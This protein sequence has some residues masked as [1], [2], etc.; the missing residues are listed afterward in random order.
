MNADQAVDRLLSRPN[1]PSEAEPYWMAFCDLSE[2]RPKESV[3]IG[4]GGS[5]QLPGNL[6]KEAIRRE[7]RRLQYAGEALDDFVAIVRGV[8]RIYVEVHVKRIADE[9][10]AAAERSRKRR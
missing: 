3:G 10:K 5:I 1:L 6:T 9:T 2:D 7:G 8:D 4:M